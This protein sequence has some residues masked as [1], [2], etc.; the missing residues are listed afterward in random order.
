LSF[1]LSFIQAAGYSEP[2]INKM[3]LAFADHKYRKCDWEGAAE[4]YART[5]GFTEPSY[6][7]KR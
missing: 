7:V 3:H 2:E 6:V 4:S 1:F 5:I